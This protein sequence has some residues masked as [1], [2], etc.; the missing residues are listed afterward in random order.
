MQ[1]GYISAGSGT[2]VDL[3]GECSTLSG[4]IFAGDGG[5]SLEVELSD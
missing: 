5:S 3:G 2:L 1:G 4:F